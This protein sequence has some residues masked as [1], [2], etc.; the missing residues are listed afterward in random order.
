M[1]LKRSLKDS[2]HG[3]NSSAIT[4]SLSLFIFFDYEAEIKSQLHQLGPL[5]KLWHR[6]HS[7]IV[8]VVATQDVVVL[9]VGWPHVHL[10][11]SADSILVFIHHFA[12]MCDPANA[13]GDSEEHS[14]HVLG[15][16]YSLID[17]ACVEIYIR[18]QLSL[19][20]VVILQSFLL[21]ID[22]QIE[23]RQGLA[24]IDKF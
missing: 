3:E 22:G 4:F 24:V 15:D 19:D 17:D 7:G 12:P 8:A 5:A 11:R 23:Q 14:E 9:P 20:K 1:V 2:S 18:V 13:P 21:Q 10:P 6:L 16:A